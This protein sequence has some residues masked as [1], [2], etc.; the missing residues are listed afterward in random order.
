MTNHVDDFLEH[1]GTKGMKWGVRKASKP[2][3]AFMPPVKG[4]SKPAWQSPPPQ[5]Q[6]SVPVAARPKRRLLGRKKTPKELS[7]D[8]A[9]FQAVRAKAK[10]KGVQS[11]TNAELRVV[12]ERMQLQKKYS[13]LF[14]KQRNPLVDAAVDTLIEQALSDTREMKINS[15]I[16]PRS[17]NSAVAVATAMTVGRAYRAATKNK[18]NKPKEKDND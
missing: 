17:P 4:G 5:K 16:G 11:L 7:E 3:P 15:F 1:Y 2:R 10:T 18:K 6:V 8:A 12:T 13:E 14:P 9:K